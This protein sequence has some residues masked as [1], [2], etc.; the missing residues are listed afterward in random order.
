MTQ[1]NIELE[2]ETCF[3]KVFN[4]CEGCNSYL[5]KTCPS[6]IP[7]K[8]ELRDK[9]NSYINNQ[10]KHFYLEKEKADIIPFPEQRTFADHENKKFSL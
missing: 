3:N 4:N 6:Y 1:K 5:D 10:S 8:I 7:A 9:L 2:V